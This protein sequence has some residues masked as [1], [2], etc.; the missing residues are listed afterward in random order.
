MF[1][2]FAYQTYKI[3]FYLNVLNFILLTCFKI[4]FYLHVFCDYAH[5]YAKNGFLIKNI[6]IK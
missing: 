4:L 1:C 6:K 3:L 2:I 5:K